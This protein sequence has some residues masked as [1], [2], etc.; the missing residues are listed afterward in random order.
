MRIFCNIDDFT[1]L[2]KTWPTQSAEV[3]RSETRVG[4]DTEN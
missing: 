4:T 2:S 3:R 1:L